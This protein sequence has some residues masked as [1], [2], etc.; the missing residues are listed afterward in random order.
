[1]KGMSET[2]KIGIVILHGKSGSPTKHVSDLASTLEAKGYLVANLEMPWSG[3][4]DYDASV[5]AAEAQ[6]EAAL[7]SLRNKGAQKVFVSGHSQGGAFTLHFAGKHAVDGIICI[8]PGGNVGS[9]SFREKLGGSV[10]RARQLVVEGKGDEKTKLE[11]FE[12]KKGTYPVVTTPAVYLTWF[13][14]EGAMNSKRAAHAANPRVPILWI[15]AQRDYPGLRET[16]LPMF[17]SLP[18]NP[19]T[20]LYEPSSD[21]LGAPSASI[22]EI[23]RWTS[24]VASTGR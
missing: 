5:S 13:D 21:H 12:G 17:A 18:K 14:P 16:N 6:V 19:H 24:K 23:V 10:E 11:D 3:N 2:P 9:K 8:A 15:V 20:R 22:D 7:S 1:M 4:R